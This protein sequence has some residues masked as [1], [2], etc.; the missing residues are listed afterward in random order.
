MTELLNTPVW[1]I[2]CGVAVAAFVVG[3]GGWLVIAGPGEMATGEGRIRG[4]TKKE[5]ESKVKEINRTGPIWFCPLIKERCVPECLNF[6][7]AEVYNKNGN[8]KLRDTKQDDYQIY[9]Q[10]CSNA[11]FMETVICPGGMID[12]SP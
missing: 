4:M 11:M 12:E 10:F 8:G 3:V 9:H 5:A 7:R 1:T 6:S 2:W